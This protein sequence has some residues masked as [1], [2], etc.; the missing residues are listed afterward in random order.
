MC[1][2]TVI[3]ILVVKNINKSISGKIC[4]VSKITGV[5]DAF[6]ST[7]GCEAKITV[8]NN[9]LLSNFWKKVQSCE[10]KISPKKAF[11]APIIILTLR[12]GLN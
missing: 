3:V 9:R 11:S 10:L 8:E 12:I 2:E 1:V 6:K 7:F 4:F 5:M